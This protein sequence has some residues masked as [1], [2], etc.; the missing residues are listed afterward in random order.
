MAE[1]KEYLSALGF[2]VPC[3]GCVVLLILF[4]ASGSEKCR[5]GVWLMFA[6]YLLLKGVRMAL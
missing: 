6:S 3:L 1:F 2:W 4:A 5:R